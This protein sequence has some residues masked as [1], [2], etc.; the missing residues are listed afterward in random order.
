MINI[1]THNRT[2]KYIPRECGTQFLCE[3]CLKD[4]GLGE[5]NPSHDAFGSAISN[6]NISALEIEVHEAD[7]DIPFRV[8]IDQLAY[9]IW[10]K[11]TS[12]C[13]QE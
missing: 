1:H 4:S 5:E 11:M 2:L 12:D 8:A 9:E 10:C 6:H 13:S 3:A 7:Y